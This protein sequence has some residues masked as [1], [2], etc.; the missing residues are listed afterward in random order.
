M[1]PSIRRH[2]RRSNRITPKDAQHAAVCG[3]LTLRGVGQDVSLDVTFNHSSTIRCHHSA[4]TAGF[5][6]T[7]K[8]SRKAFRDGCVADPSSAT[9]VEL[10]IRGR[11]GARAELEDKR[12]T[13]PGTATAGC[14]R[15]TSHRLHAPIRPTS[16]ARPTNQAQPT[17]PHD[18]TR[19]NT[20]TLRNSNERWGPRSQALHWLIVILILVMAYLGLT[21]VDL[22]TTP[23]KDLRLHAS[24]KY[25]RHH[26][27][28]AG[29]AAA[30]V[31]GCTRARLARSPGFPPGNHGSRR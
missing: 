29:R 28:G 12:R 23:H 3:T 11:S 20:M 22:P 18:G 1:S 31:G 4:A 17:E 5:S 14:G 15:R 2:V 27:P 19:Q 16:P 13:N 7:A 8:L 25:R 26:D 30:G 9:R 6:A 21:M 10:R 24:H